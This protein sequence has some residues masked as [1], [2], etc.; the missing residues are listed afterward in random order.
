MFFRHEPSLTS[1]K[2]KSFELRFVRTHPFTT[3]L[4]MAVLD[5]SSRFILTLFICFTLLVV[6]LSLLYDALN[7]ILPICLIHQ[8]FT[9]II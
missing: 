7:E 5:A 3:T 9:E 2:E 6:N 1:M 4:S 8:N